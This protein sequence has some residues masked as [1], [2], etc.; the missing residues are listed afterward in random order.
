MVTVLLPGVVEALDELLEESM[1]LVEDGKSQDVH[2]VI[3]QAVQSL[4]GKLLK[5]SSNP[6]EKAALG[7]GVR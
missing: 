1:R 4:E 2:P 5:Q 7:D 6:K 3:Q